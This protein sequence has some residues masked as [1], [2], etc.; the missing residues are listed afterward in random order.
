MGKAGH[1]F[2][3]NQML[4]CFFKLIILYFLKEKLYDSKMN[5]LNKTTLFIYDSSLLAI[6]FISTLLRVAIR[7]YYGSTCYSIW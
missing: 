4:F 3:P 2:G 5:K 7:A 6:Y 1:M